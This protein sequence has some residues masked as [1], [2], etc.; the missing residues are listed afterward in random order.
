M[1]MSINLHTTT[2][3]N[4]EVRAKL[5]SIE[6][7]S[8]KYPII[9]ISATPKGSYDYQEISIFPSFEQVK[10]LHQEL[11]NLMKKIEELENVP[12]E[13]KTELPF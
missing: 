12:T 11:S 13:D 10:Q 3:E 9:Q 2:A 7:G 1:S 8:E 4:F 5:T 6:Y